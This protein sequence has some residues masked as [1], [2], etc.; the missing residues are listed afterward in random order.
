MKFEIGSEAILSYRR[1]DYKPWHAIAEFV[2]N[3]TQAY[4]SNEKSLQKSFKTKNT[5]LDITI[6]YD[7]EDDVLRITDNSFGMDEED[8][9]RAMTVGKRPPNTSGRSKY[10]MGLKTAACWFGDKWKIVTKKL[11]CDYEYEIEIDV[12]KIAKGTTELRPKKTKKNS[13]E[14]YTL[15][16]ITQ[17]QRKMHTRTLGKIQEYLASMYRIDLKTDKIQIKWNN[18]L[19]KWEDIDDE[20]LKDKSGKKFK[21]EIKF[22]VHGKEVKG[23]VGILESGGR[24]KA[25]FTVFHCNRVVM[26][27]PN[28]WKPAGVFG[29]QEG[30]SNNLVSQR[31][32]GEF[33][34]DDFEVT[35]TKDNIL[36]DGDEE[37]DVVDKI[38]EYCEDYI[39]RAQD[40]RKRSEGSRPD[41][42]GPSEEDIEVAKGDL[43]EELSSPEM[44]DVIRMTTVPPAS[45]LI[46]SDK[47]IAKSVTSSSEPW[48]VGKI[49][50]LEIKIFL[51]SSSPNDPYVVH[52][53][54]SDREVIVIINKDHPFFT[55]IEG[56]SGVLNYA[57]FCTY[58]AL[59]EWKAAKL[60]GKIDLRVIKRIKDEL[61]RLPLEIEEHSAT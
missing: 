12:N 46:Q 41:E 54:S 8:L 34:L 15:I 40:R 13:S 2:D 27:V 50:K 56:A 4:F 21:K 26:G 42:R 10:G 11:D 3:T 33:H 35:H 20:I 60:T 16:E 23:W 43:Q 7:A 25:G 59:A 18:T 37:F 22:K 55:Q 31:L 5:C 48:C 30:G 9:K 44:I 45:T 6:V 61:L 51:E 17:L 52:E 32:I 29:N 36:W 58:D 1:L 19:L 57:R 24:S 47:K 39:K 38:R 14:H 28:S 53:S 49:D